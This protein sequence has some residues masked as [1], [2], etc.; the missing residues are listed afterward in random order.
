MT[1]KLI[2]PIVALATLAGCAMAP[3]PVPG[4]LA[5][6]GLGRDPNLRPSPGKRASAASTAP[7]TNDEREKALATLRPYSE[8]WWV[9]HDEIEAEKDRRIGARLVIC[10]GCFPRA[11]ED[12]VTGSIR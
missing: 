4:R 7:D 11:A 3:P 10:R 8:A 6:D 9:V 1:F 12:E 2:V 5:W